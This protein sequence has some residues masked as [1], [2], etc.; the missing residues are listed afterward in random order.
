MNYLI[1]SQLSAISKLGMLLDQCD[2]L[3]KQLTVKYSIWFDL[4]NNT[5]SAERKQ[6]AIEFSF[7]LDQLNKIYLNIEV[8]SSHN[9]T[10][11]EAYSITMLRINNLVSHSFFSRVNNRPLTRNK[12]ALAN[13]D[14]FYRT[15]SKKISIQT[16]ITS[17]S[18]NVGLMF[19]FSHFIKA[20]IDPCFVDFQS[21]DKHATRIADLFHNHS[22]VS[23]APELIIFKELQEITKKMSTNCVLDYKLYR[24]GLEVDMGY[25][26][27]KGYTIKL[28]GPKVVVDS[29]ECN[30]A[31]KVYNRKKGQITA[32]IPL[33]V[34]LKDDPFVSFAEFV[35]NI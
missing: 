34:S 35:S 9:C 33:E 3:N 18:L 31:C 19:N 20:L 28:T 8:V 12:L 4:D 17:C 13:F 27:L 6:A 2:Q 7:D 1:F 15:E 10:L 26:R 30:T 29:L 5:N 16:S 22:S 11:E 21:M 25:S 23:Y 24:S 32:F 14:Q